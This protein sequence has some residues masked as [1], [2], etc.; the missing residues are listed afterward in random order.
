MPTAGHPVVYGELLEAGDDAPTMLLYGH[1]DVQPEEPLELWESDP[2]EAEQRGE[3]LY[4]RGASDMKGQVMASINAVEAALQNGGIGF[5]LKFLIEGEEEIGSENLDIFIQENKDLLACDFSLNPDAGMLAA[6]KPTITYSLRGMAY[7]EIHV[8]GPD[9]DLHSGMYGGAVRN[10]INELARLI[11]GMMD[12]DGRIMLPG[13]YDSVRDLDD[14]E[15]AELG[16]LPLG[17]DF[18][19]K[20]HGSTS[21]M[22]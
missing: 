9:H 15:R 13:F 19:Y 17:D 2:F 14:E 4:A 5:N 16:R 21:F 22:G 1:Y 18:L 7:F 12:E 10:P 3:N 6:D 8:E 20:Q 11:G